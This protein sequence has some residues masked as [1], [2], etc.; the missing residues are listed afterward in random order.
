MSQ[1][2]IRDENHQHARSNQQTPPHAHL[3]NLEFDP[4]PI[5]IIEPRASTNPSTPQT[6]R[7]MLLQDVID[8]L[9]RN[10]AANPHRELGNRQASDLRAR[11]NGKRLAVIHRASGASVSAAMLELMIVLARA[12]SSHAAAAG[13]LASK[14]R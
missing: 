8:E 1:M 14:S 7:T 13:V 12:N 6:L 3:P 2:K 9:V 5:A 11:D 10:G 4:S